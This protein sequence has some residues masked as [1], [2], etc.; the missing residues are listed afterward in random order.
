MVLDPLINGSTQVKIAGKGDSICVRSSEKGARVIRSFI[1]IN[2]T[3][4][5]HGSFYTISFPNTQSPTLIISH[6][7]TYLPGGGGLGPT[8]CLRP[9]PI[10]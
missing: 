4:I 10:P 6:A 1:I 8:I 2:Q 3:I 7:R 5:A 9:L